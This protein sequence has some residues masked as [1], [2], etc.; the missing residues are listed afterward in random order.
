[1]EM[2]MEMI[3]IPEL[4]KQGVSDFIGRFVSKL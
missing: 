1:M 3:K 2:E 4:W